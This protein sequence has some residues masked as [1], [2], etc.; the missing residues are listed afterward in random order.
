[1]VVETELYDTLGVAPDASISEIKKAYKIL[2]LKYH[3]DKNPDKNAEDM[4]KKITGAYEI[5]SDEEK[6]ELYNIH[7]K[8]GLQ[9]SGT[10]PQ[11]IFSSLFGS[12]F[13]SPFNIFNNMFKAQNVTMR[14]KPFVYERLV[15]L[16]DLCT[17]KIINIKVTRDRVCKCQKT[18]SSQVKCEKCD[19]KGQIIQTT[20]FL[21]MVQQVRFAC[22]KCKGVGL[23]SPY[24]GECKNG[25]ID[26][27]K[28]FSIHL[29]PEIYS[30]YQYKFAGEGNEVFGVLP[31]DFIVTIKHKPHAQ[32][33]VDKQDLVYNRETTLLE[34]LCGY[35]ALVL[36]PSGSNVEISVKGVVSPSEKVVV[37]NK[38][39][40]ENGNMIVVHNI[41]F[42]KELKKEQIKKLKEILS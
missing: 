42:P 3:P 14:T 17:R 13:S 32:F 26:D 35:N 33:T 22:D 1:M 30:G 25:I 40:D 2:A 15:T 4:F 19:G 31:G 41:I 28:V 12:S 24:C 23:C 18:Q 21:N 34:A 39:L 6:R 20:N 9:S 7:G 29:T 11:D 36:H 27:P 38:G 16:E 5:L 8:N 10:V 37:P